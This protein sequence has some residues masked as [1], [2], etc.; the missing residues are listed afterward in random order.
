[1]SSASAAQSNAVIAVNGVSF[2]YG[3]PLV[4]RNIELTIERG[5]FIGLVGP[6]GSGKSTLLELIL[7]LLSPTRGSIQ[8]CGTTPLQGRQRIGY[9]SQFASFSRDFPITVEEMVMLGGLTTGSLFGSFRTDERVAARTA[10]AAT[11]VEKL[12]RRRL[13]ELSGGELQRVMIARAMVGVPE[14]L[15]LDESTANVDHHAGE[16]IFDLLRSLQETMTIVVVS[17]DIGFISS[18]VDRVACLNQVLEVHAVAEI[19][20]E[21]LARLYGGHVAMID[22]AH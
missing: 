1:V 16:E 21:V 20:Q 2:S 8:V 5:E 19:D 3:G 14:I 15:I 7:G 13:S 12:G 9:C 22:H 11:D 17:H 18:Y 4:L 10:M 6:N